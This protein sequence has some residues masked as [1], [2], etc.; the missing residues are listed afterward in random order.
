MS[1]HLAEFSLRVWA[2]GFRVFS[3]FRGLGF[4][5]YRVLMR[6]FAE[7]LFGGKCVGWLLYLLHFTPRS[8][9]PQLLCF[10]R[11]AFPPLYVDR[12]AYAKRWGQQAPER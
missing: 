7:G 4:R 5:G 12:H 2:L 8:R 11:P 9:S 10:C 3:A 6:A 1:Q